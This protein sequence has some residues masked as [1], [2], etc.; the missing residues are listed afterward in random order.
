MLLV[1]ELAALVRLFLL[2]LLVAHKLEESG[3]H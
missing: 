3:V 2:L 1:G